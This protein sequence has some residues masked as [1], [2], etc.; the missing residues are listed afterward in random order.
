MKSDSQHLKDVN[1]KLLLSITD[2]EMVLTKLK[3]D[4][5]T[6]KLKSDLTQAFKEVA[7]LKNKNGKATL[8]DFLNEL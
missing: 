2:L 5:Q 3:K 1:G 7:L 8:T 4:D 6:S